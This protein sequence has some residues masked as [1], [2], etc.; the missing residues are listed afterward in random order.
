[1]TTDGLLDQVGGSKRLAFG[2]RRFRTFLKQS[3]HMTLSE[4]ADSL[5]ERF[6]NYQGSEVRRDDVSVIGFDPSNEAEVSAL[7]R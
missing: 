2:K 6:Q 5:L 1:M 3:Q 4:Q 7:T